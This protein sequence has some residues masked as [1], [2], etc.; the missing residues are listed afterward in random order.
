MVI[1]SYSLDLW[2][3]PP[4]TRS[5]VL[6]LASPPERHFGLPAIVDIDEDGRSPFGPFGLFVGRSA[7]L[8]SV[9]TVS[10]MSDVVNTMVDLSAKINN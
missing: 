10:G 2:Y 6:L 9:Y 7:E 3:S 8:R 1:G 5:I 4:P